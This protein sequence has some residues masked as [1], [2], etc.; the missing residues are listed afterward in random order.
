MSPRPL[1]LCAIYLLPLIFGV[2]AI[3]GWLRLRAFLQA[4]TSIAN[5]LELDD[6]KRLVKV[7][8]LLALTVVVLL[9]A[10]VGLAGIGVAFSLIPWTA[11]RGFFILGPACGL[12]AVK[13]NIA[14]GQVRNMPLDNESLR[15]EFNHIL[16]TWTHSMLPDW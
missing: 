4:H 13:L 7:D 11:L 6:L 16:E 1:I 15:E 8:M 12:A 14:E 9:V 3:W 5:Q 2:M 10:A